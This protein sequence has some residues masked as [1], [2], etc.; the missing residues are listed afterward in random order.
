MAQLSD[1]GEVGTKSKQI[2]CL[3]GTS[4]KARKWMEQDCPVLSSQLSDR[5][6]VNFDCCN[7]TGKK[8]P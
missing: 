8:W 2:K 5:Q 7:L 6:T 1:I 4:G 3:G